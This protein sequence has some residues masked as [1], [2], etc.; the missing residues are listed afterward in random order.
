[1]WQG[2]SY[3]EIIHELNPRTVI[4]HTH[5]CHLD[6]DL[7]AEVYQREVGWMPAFGQT[8][9]SLTELYENGVCVGDLFLFFGWFKETEYKNGKLTFKGCSINYVGLVLDFM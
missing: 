3:L 2:K 4:S 8:G 5:H 1:M 7:R 6:P 9:A